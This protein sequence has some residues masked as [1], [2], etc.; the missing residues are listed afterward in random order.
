MSNLPAESPF[1]DLG[2]RQTAWDG[3]SDRFLGRNGAPD[4]PAGLDLGYRLQGAAGAGMDPCAACRPASSSP[5]ERRPRS[6]CCSARRTGPPRR[7]TSSGAGERPTTRRRCAAW[8]ATGTIPGRCPGADTRPLDGY[9]AQPAG[10]STRRSHAGC[11]RG[12]RS[13]R[14]AAHTGSATSSRTSSPLVILEARSRPGA[15]LEGHG[16]SVR[17]GRRP[18]LWHPPSGQGIRT[19]ISGRS[20]LAPYAVGRYLAV[21]GDMAVLDGVRPLSRGTGTAAG[22]DGRLLPAGTLTG[23]GFVVRPLCGG[24]WTGAGSGRPRAAAHRDGRTGTTA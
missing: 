5:M 8:R 7:P 9:H 24:L 22:P 21:T 3:R 4:R 23:V 1:L 18:A 15:S 13:T 11:G 16:P 20:P 2:G 14:Q 19:R 17:R 12:R 6:S 10:S